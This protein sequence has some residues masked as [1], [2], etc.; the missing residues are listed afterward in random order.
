[1]ALPPKKTAANPFTAASL[2]GGSPSAAP[3]D[4]AGAGGAGADA[5]DDSDSDPTPILT[6]YSTGDGGYAISQ[7]APDDG[8]SADPGD[9]G[10]AGAGPAMAAD[11]GAGADGSGGMQSFPNLG[12]TLKA[13]MTI[14]QGQEDATSGSEADNFNSGYSG[15]SN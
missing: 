10:G 8:A 15:A 5:A 4:A 11:G 6:I 1:M 14:I 13:V 9:V 7:G 12:A 2:A 3:G